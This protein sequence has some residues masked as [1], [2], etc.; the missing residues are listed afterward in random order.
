MHA[1]EI[2]PKSQ[3][4]NSI[5][6]IQKNRVQSHL[7]PQ[8]IQCR[9]IARNA[10][11]DRCV[12][13]GQTLCCYRQRYVHHP[14]SQSTAKTAFSH[15]VDPIRAQRMIHAYPPANSPDTARAVS[16]PRTLAAARMT[17]TFQ[18]IPFRIPCSSER[19]P[20]R[21][22]PGRLFTLNRHQRLFRQV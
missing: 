22:Y 14:S 12:P 17:G 2:L 19:L 20:R 6:A 9:L 18:V 8:R 11:E 5:L 15:Q 13:P 1:I 3:L 4:R 21:E 10:C 7:G 16:Y